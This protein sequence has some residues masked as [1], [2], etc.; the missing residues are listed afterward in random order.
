MEIEERRYF[1]ALIMAGMQT[2]NPALS[3]KAEYLAKYAV[4]MADALIAELD[5]EDERNSTEI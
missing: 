5:K 2:E 1:A 3:N 4:E